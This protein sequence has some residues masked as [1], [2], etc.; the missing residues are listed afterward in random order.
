MATLEA[1][2]CREDLEIPESEVRMESKVPTDLPDLP[3]TLE[4]PEEPD[5]TGSREAREVPVFPVRVSGVP[6]EMP[7]HLGVLVCSGNLG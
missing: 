4:Q 6:P 1:G 3:E 7:E 5:W 2:E